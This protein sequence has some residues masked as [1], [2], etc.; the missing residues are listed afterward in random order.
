MIEDELIAK[1]KH[2]I[3]VEEAALSKLSIAVPERSFLRKFAEDSFKMIKSYFEDAKFFYAKGDIINAF[4]SLNY[5]Y[6][7]I[8][9]GVRLGIFDGMRDQKLFTLYE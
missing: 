3:E 7:W 1:V 9:S 2:Y 4:A 5:S 8:D 6:G